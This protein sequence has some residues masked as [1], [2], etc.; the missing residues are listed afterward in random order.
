MA[1]TSDQIQADIA[2][3]RQR[4]ASGLD[5]AGRRT[6]TSSS[7][8]SQALTES[9][10]QQVREHPL[11]AIG[12]S[13]FAGSLLKDYMGGQTA[14]SNRSVGTQFRA[15]GYSE[16]RPGGAVDT[17]RGV[18]HD[19]TD[20][21]GD[22]ARHVADTAG[23]VVDH[24]RDSAEYAAD[25]AGDLLS[26]VSSAVTRQVR[27]RPLVTVG[28][29]LLA[30]S[31]LKDYFAGSQTTTGRRL[32]TGTSYDYGESRRN[33]SYGS[34]PTVAATAG[35]TIDRA[36]HAAGEAV[37]RTRDAAGAA[38]DATRHAAGTVI[39]AT[40]DA[41]SAAVDKT[42]DT[43]RMVAHATTDAAHQVAE[44]TIDAADEVR[45]RAN[46]LLFTASQQ[47]QRRP[48]TTLGLAIGAGMLLQPSLQPHVS[49]IVDGVRRPVSRISRSVTSL[50][51]LPVQPEVDKIRTKL[52]PVTVD[53]ARQYTGR[54]L[55]E[56]LDHSLESVIAQP[57][58]RAGLVA[59]V[60]ERAEQLTDSRL[61][62]LLD[63]NLK[64]TRGLL[65]LALVGAVLR[66][67]SQAKQGQGQT[68]SNVKNELSQSLT[69]TAREQLMAHFPAFRE[70]YQAGENGS[71][72][73]SN[74][75]SEVASNARF[76]PNCGGAVLK[77]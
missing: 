6:T 48:L 44:T 18:A 38:V 13:L 51:E 35:Q 58:L 29:S 36:E 57:S 68:I 28:V 65:L 53:R 46:D 70:Q 33:P 20:T 2:R 7:G 8:D 25:Q 74:C 1:Q 10:G 56:Y 64:G 63:R 61:P 12:L 41:A 5:N 42:V 43:A 34:R 77:A 37:D 45:D 50:V 11:L 52:V 55:R 49:G 54:E 69:T 19:V 67:Q 23:D 21:A 22:A 9:L 30:G 27:E 75:G 40:Q 14:G 60:T 17:A 76:C 26:S 73:C 62:D 39:D 4:M 31:L 47:V 3:T 72:R 16:Y 32:T 71:Q 66:A 59:A 24:V 15:G